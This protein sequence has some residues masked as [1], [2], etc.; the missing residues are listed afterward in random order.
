MANFVARARTS[1]KDIGGLLL[2]VDRDGLVEAQG[3]PGFL[4]SWTNTARG[5]PGGRLGNPFQEIASNQPTIN[6]TGNVTVEFDRST[7]QF[8]K[9]PVLGD[10]L[11]A[12]TADFAIAFKFVPGADTAFDQLVFSDN[13]QPNAEQLKVFRRD[14]AGDATIATGAA[15]GA[16]VSGDLPT[17]TYLYSANAT[18]TVWEQN[19]AAFGTGTADTFLLLPDLDVGYLLGSGVGGTDFLDGELE[20]FQIWGKEL[21]PREQDLAWQTLDKDASFSSDV[22]APMSTPVWSDVTGDLALGQVD[23]LSPIVGA[24]HRYI[25]GTIPTGTPSFVQIG[26]EVGGVTLPD[27]LLGGDLFTLS[28]LEVPG[29]PGPPPLVFQ[30]A[31]W[32]SIFDIQVDVGGHYCVRVDRPNGG[33]FLVHFDIE[34]TP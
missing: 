31:G 21:S 33:G 2:D 17:G 10:P 13:G 18:S 1:Y 19:G 5:L 25:L 26:A 24:P 23:R 16:T 32:S 30:D 6:T 4:G 3:N 20:S 9:I 27:S 22:R 29:P 12:A 11:P 14:S 7:S 28:F 8:L 15:G 34:V